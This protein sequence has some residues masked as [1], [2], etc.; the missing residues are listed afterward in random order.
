MEI[1]LTILKSLFE[2][3]NKLAAKDFAQHFLG[4]E[5]VFSC[6]DPTGVIGREAAGRNDA[7][8]MRVNAELL[9]PCVQYAEE[10]DLC[11]EVSRIARDFE[12]SF[13]TGAEQEVVENFLVLQNER[14]QA[15]GESL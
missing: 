6:V 15:T 3:I 5:V 14:R 7:M 12:Q 8:D 2:S 1:K 9:I 10:A 11:T 13:R 4:K